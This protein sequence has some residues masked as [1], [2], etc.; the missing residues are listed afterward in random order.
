MV[1]CVVIYFYF[2]QNKIWCYTRPPKVLVTY[3]SLCKMK[4]KKLRQFAYFKLL[5]PCCQPSYKIFYFTC[6]ISRYTLFQNLTPQIIMISGSCGNSKFISEPDTLKIIMISGSCVVS[7]STLFQNLIFIINT[8]S[9]QI[10]QN[11]LPQN[12]IHCN[13]HDFWVMWYQQIYIISKP[14][15]PKLS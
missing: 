1:K 5:G 4:C 6:G 9:T 12:L 7:K 8:M 3:I 15:N 10:L 13:Y 11:I 14:D 2:Y